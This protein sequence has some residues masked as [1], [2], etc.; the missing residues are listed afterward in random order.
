MDD[1]LLVINKFCDG[2][3]F[4]LIRYDDEFGK[5]VK[6]IYEAD[7]SQNEIHRSIKN[8]DDSILFV[9]T[10]IPE[11]NLFVLNPL[12]LL[13]YS[14][15]EGRAIEAVYPHIFNWIYDGLYLK[16]YAIIPSHDPKAHSTI[17][18]YGGSINFYKILTQHLNNIGK[19]KKGQSPDYDFSH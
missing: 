8:R 1:R 18:R 4:Y 10:I 6:G 3:M 17:S 19:M 16:A 13:L 12:Q 5:I 14:L 9:Y 2:A 11:N 15:E 7:I